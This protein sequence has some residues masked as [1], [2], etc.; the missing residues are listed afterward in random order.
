MIA[1]RLSVGLLMIGDLSN[2]IRREIA[3]AMRGVHPRVGTVQSYDPNTHS[4]KV[5]YQPDGTL[6][7]WIPIGCKAAGSLVSHVHGPAIGDQ[8]VVTF[9]GGDIES[10]FVSHYLHS[11]QNRPP[12]AQSGET[13]LAHTQNPGQSNQTQTV[14]KINAAGSVT[15]TTGANNASVSTTTTGAGASVSTT[16]QGNNSSVTTSTN[17]TGASVTTTT[18]SGDVTTTS[19]SGNVK[20]N[21]KVDINS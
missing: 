11:D 1:M 8:A 2:L 14:W 9:L 19:G 4:V 15:T 13:V 7:G 6:S 18:N 21:G 16:T 5:A 12:I 17:G 3:R 10:G 20:V